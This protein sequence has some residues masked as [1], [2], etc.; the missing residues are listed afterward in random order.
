MGSPDAVSVVL[1]AY[2]EEELLAG[3][4]DELGTDL[5]RLG[6]RFE[7]IVVENG[8]KDRTRAIAD[9]LAPSVPELRAL[10]LPTADYGRALRAGFL[11]ATGDVVV[12]FDVE[13]YSVDF[14][15]AAVDRICAPGGPAVV[16]G[17]KRAEGADDTR[18]LHRRVVTAAFAG[19][20]R[21][22]FGLR[23]SD[24]HGMK[25]LDRRRLLPL[26]EACRLG[27][28]L[29][30]SELILRA[31]R[32]GVPVEE[33]P[34]QVVERRPSRTS[35]ATRAARSTVGLVRLHQALRA[36]PDPG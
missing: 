10:S 13:Y 32:A 31:E 30:D 4:I 12:N 11:A 19:L 21:H 29:F 27:T 24:T 25:A 34:V 18:A 9:E 1:P 7:L 3:T 8:S 36:A 5:R 35:I 2:N 15:V 33:L 28:D 16:I 20:L 6:R 14:L 17:S 26:V 22:G 23:A